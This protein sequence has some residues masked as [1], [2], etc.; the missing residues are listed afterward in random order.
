ML[1][2]IEKSKVEE[3]KQKTLRTIDKY[4]KQQLNI[5]NTIAE[6]T[7]NSLFNATNINRFTN[8]PTSKYVPKMN[9]TIGSQGS[10]SGIAGNPF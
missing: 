4:S 1:D 2:E 5:K 6:N 9:A 10:G 7:A 8:V 3:I